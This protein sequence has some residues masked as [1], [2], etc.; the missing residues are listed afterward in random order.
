[1]SDLAVS[2]SD[3]QPRGGRVDGVATADAFVR[4]FNDVRA[5]LVST[6]YFM[7]GNNEDAQ[8]AAQDAF[9]KCLRTREGLGDVQNV[10]AWIFRVG[11]NTAKDLQRN[12]W[13][14]RARPVGDAPLP[15][16]PKEGSSP[17]DAAQEKEALDRLRVALLELRTE[18]KEVFLLRQN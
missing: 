13:R 8:D 12:A 4:A 2:T 17:C 10:R 1:M 11:L 9:L 18:E 7:L 15:E 3:V 16:V 5:E 14:R 6:L